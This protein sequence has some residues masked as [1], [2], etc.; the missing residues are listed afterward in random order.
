MINNE[1]KL[2][3]R[4][5]PGLIWIKVNGLI[6]FAMIQKLYEASRAGVKI[7]LIVRGVCALIPGVKGM[8]E[9]IE[10]I[11]V[12]DK[13]LE[14]SRIYIFGNDGAPKHYISSADLMTRNLDHRIEV[15]C[16]IYDLT[17]QKELHDIFDLQWKDNTKARLHNGAQSHQY[18]KK[19]RGQKSTR[20]QEDIYN[21][22]KAR[23]TSG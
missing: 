8:S 3:K 21:Y 16:P 6:D 1:I 9:N 5:K 14:H 11:S 20:E 7:R 2:A 18:K 19:G 4:G 10:A 13:F 22:L 15:A 17:L 12:V 23:H